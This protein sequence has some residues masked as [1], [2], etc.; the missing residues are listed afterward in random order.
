MEIL[1]KYLLLL[2]AVSPLT[3]RAQDNF[4]LAFK[5]SLADTQ[6]SFEYMRIDTINVEINIPIFEGL[7]YHKTIIKELI[8]RLD[9][10]SYCNNR[11]CEVK[12]LY[13]VEHASSGFLSIQEEVYTENRLPRD[14]SHIKF[15][16]FLI[17]E[18]EVIEVKLNT[19][20][21]TLRSK[22]FKSLEM[23]S[24]DPDCH[25]E[26]ETLNFYLFVKDGSTHVFAYKNEVC[27]E[28]LELL[29]EPSDLSF[30][31]LK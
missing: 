31:S 14:I 13:K 9:P 4:T 1:Q 29:P 6:F 7:Q 17:L 25:Y 21:P 18:D 23:V 12:V 15:F 19:D 28:F 27:N 20:L 11:G 8:K 16:N 2:L 26:E 30:S 3:C 24:S 5:K 10:E 22:V